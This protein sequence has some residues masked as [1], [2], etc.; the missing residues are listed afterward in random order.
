MN[1][2]QAAMGICNL[3]H[4]NTEIEKRKKIVEHYR[5][6]LEGVEDTNFLLSR[7][8]WKVTMPTFQLFL[9]VIST[10]EMKYLKNWRKLVLEQENIS[11][12]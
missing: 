7:R 3:K 2:F 10:L 4:L 5:S 6:R 11:I 9:M 8:M 12:R 1:E